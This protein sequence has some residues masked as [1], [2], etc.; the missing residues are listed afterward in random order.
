M[1]RCSERK[2]LKNDIPQVVGED[3]ISDTGHDDF[4]QRDIGCVGKAGIDLLGRTSVQPAESALKVAPGGVEIVIVAIVVWEVMLDGR[5]GNFLTEDVDLVEEE[6]HGCAGEPLAVAD[7]VK[8][9]QG[10]LH[11]IRIFV[12]D[13]ARI[14]TGERDAEE[15]SGDIFKAVDPLFA[16]G[17]LTTHVK[18][19]IDSILERERGFD[20]SGG[21]VTTSKDIVLGGRVGRRKEAIEIGIVVRHVVR[22]GCFVASSVN[23]LNAVILPQIL[24]GHE[25]VR[26]ERLVFGNVGVRDKERKVV[27]VAIVTEVDG[28]FFHDIEDGF[29]ALNQIEEYE[30]TEVFSLLV[31]EGDV[32]NDTHR[33]EDSRF[34]TFTSAEKEELDFSREALFIF[35][36]LTIE[37]SRL[38][39]FGRIL[40]LSLGGHACS[41]LG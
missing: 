34:S 27:D 19:A 7:R 20:D 11:L 14:V 31:G 41:H 33:L 39:V 16:F 23:R 21:L 35:L 2:Q 9:H 1:N 38:L 36:D 4:Q 5:V 3:D 8:E 17:S 13:E 25:I 6:N 18:D 32:M 15:D 26:R 40:G 22:D 28:P 24:E 29:H 10:F 12:F 30:A 37:R